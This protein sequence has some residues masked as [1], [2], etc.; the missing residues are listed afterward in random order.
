[1]R[2]LSGI[3]E[4]KLIPEKAETPLTVIRTEIDQSSK[5]SSRESIEKFWY[6]QNAKAILTT[7]KT[8]LIIKVRLLNYNRLPCLLMP[9]LK[10]FA[11][12]ADMNS[13]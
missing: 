3:W 2:V 1:V 12:N 10:D 8:K 5:I 11:K 7:N 6:A 13:I 9:S 4:I